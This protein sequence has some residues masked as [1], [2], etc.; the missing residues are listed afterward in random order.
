MKTRLKRDL[1]EPLTGCGPGTAVTIP[2]KGHESGSVSLHD[3][4][5]IW[6]WK[7]GILKVILIPMKERLTNSMDD[8]ASQSEGEQANVLLMWA[9]TRRCSPDLGWLFI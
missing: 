5:P 8:C 3:I 9:A 6:Y 4:V 7:A 1:F 2:P